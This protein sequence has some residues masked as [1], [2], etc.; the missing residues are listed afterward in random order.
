MIILLGLLWFEYGYR[1]QPEQTKEQITAPFVAPLL[2]PQEANIAKT[3]VELEHDLPNSKNHSCLPPEVDLPDGQTYQLN[4][5]LPFLEEQFSLELH[6]R[7]RVLLANY[8]RFVGKHRM[9][10]LVFNVRFLTP[11]QFD[12]FLTSRG[13]AGASYQ[14]IYYPGGNISFVKVI[15]NEQALNTAI[16]EIT[17]AVNAQ[18]F[19]GGRF[20]RFLNEGL[21]EF[22]EY[23]PYSAAN[24][25]HKKKFKVLDFWTQQTAK[26]ELLDFYTLINSEQD[27][28]TSNNL[29]LYY[30]GALWTQFLMSQPKG[31]IAISELLK[32]KAD[33]PCR[34][35][36]ADD[37]VDAFVQHYP[38]FEQ[39]FYYYFDELLSEIE[40]E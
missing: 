3:A 32:A 38:D 15:T 22:F 7:I 36:S 19:G 39:D 16:H 8:E 30:S 18:L 31:I 10:N 6:T 27:W 12:D 14:G 11:S 33:R 37:V 21:A 2:K 5:H 28:H 40:A 29:S 26:N 34:A 17:H 1:K 25:G 35:M 24:Q 23:Y 4:A 9:R 13:H 20:P